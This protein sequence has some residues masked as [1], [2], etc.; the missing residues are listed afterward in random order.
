MV[1]LR[2]I[3]IFEIIASC[4][5]PILYFLICLIWEFDIPKLLFLYVYKVFC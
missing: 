1:L 5:L 4:I 2:T 3:L